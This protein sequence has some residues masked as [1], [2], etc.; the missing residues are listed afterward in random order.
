MKSR[1]YAGTE[2]GRS[3]SI[4]RVD[5]SFQGATVFISFRTI[6][7][8]IVLSV[9]SVAAYRFIRSNHQG[10]ASISNEENYTVQNLQTATSKI[11]EEEGIVFPES[12]TLLL[13]TSDIEDIKAG[14]DFQDELRAAI[15]EIYARNN[16]DFKNDSITEYYLQFEWYNPARDTV[17]WED[18]NEIEQAN[19]AL[20]IHVEEEYGF[21]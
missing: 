12:S 19:L 1:F 20:L 14:G 3:L 6:L 8:I 16:L 13:S 15:N 17:P 4:R 5:E 7:I 2:D 10:V 11:E 21:R 9:F 18:F